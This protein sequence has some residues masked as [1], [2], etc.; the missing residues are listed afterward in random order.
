MKAASGS[1]DAATIRITTPKNRGVPILFIADWHMG[2]WGTSLDKVA[3]VTDWILSSG[4]RIAVL[5]DM[6][7]MAIK[8]RGVLEMS[9]NALPPRLQVRMLESWLTDLAPQVLWSVWDNHCVIREEDATGF[10]H[11]AELFKDT[12]IYHSGIG[13]VDLEIAC[14]AKSQTYRIATSHRFAGNTTANPVSGTVKYMRQHGIDRELAIA[15]DV[16]VPHLQAYPEGPM[17]RIALNCG[18]LQLDS[19]Y[20]KRFFSPYAHDW[21]PIVQFYPDEHLMVPFQS[22]SHYDRRAG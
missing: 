1:Q 3:E 12:T 7:Q 4:I 16:H 18:T 11:C 17:T 6:L 9:D 14:G 20:G 21:M 2:S 5:G 10:S 22:T 13:H 15:A 19:G 8:L